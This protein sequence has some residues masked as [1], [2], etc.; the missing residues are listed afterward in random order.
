[1]PRA[2]EILA[3]TFPQIVGFDA[4]GLT[5]EQVHYFLGESAGVAYFQYKFLTEASQS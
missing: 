1:M 5:C 3:E 4:T 2:A